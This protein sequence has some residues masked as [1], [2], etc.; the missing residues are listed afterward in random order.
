VR[1]RSGICLV[2][3]LA[4][5]AGAGIFGVLA[6]RQAAEISAYDHARACRAGAP[7]RADCLQHV[8]GA[9]TGVIEI[10]GKSQ[11]YA[12]DVRTA[13]TTLHVTF[14][15]D[16]PMLSDAVDG[17]PV[18]VTTWRGIPVAASADG[19]IEATA[20]VP[21]TAFA[22]DLGELALCGGG[23]ILLL[24]AAVGGRRGR[25]ATGQPFAR[26]VLAAWIM[27]LGLG[28]PLVLI[29]GGGALVT[30]PSAPGFALAVTGAA[31]FVVVGLGAWLAI[32]AGRRHRKRPADFG[33]RLPPLPKKRRPLMSRMARSLRARMRPAT[34][35]AVPG[36]GAAGWV[37]PLL[38]MAVLFGV[39]FT[40]RD[41]PPARAFRHAPACAGDARLAACVGDFTATVNGVRTPVQDSANYV[42]VS[43]VTGDDIINGWA[44]FDGDGQALGR[45]AEAEESERT[46][47]TIEVWRGSIVGAE[48]GDRW[49]WADG[50]PPGDTVPVVF[51]AIS[52]AVLLL[53]VRLG[54]HRRDGPRTGADR[55]RMVVEDSGQAAAAG[56]ATTLLAYGFWPGAIL[57]LAA[58]VWLGQSALRSPQPPL[59]AQAV[60]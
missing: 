21:E 9:V 44:Q 51:L 40:V 20:T 17:D 45:M 12:L 2:L 57:A 31:L 34:W 48:L 19:R 7:L 14:T 28:V 39:L 26:P 18:A 30:S 5:L 58:L 49:R 6:V 4:F 25:R 54:I 1:F 60:S 38:T 23:A 35:N 15:S 16:S 55:Q 32:Y 46:P 33:V 22:Q 36:S 52:F 41:G 10:G 27:V 47:L 59:P 29:A 53:V 50:D 37:T 3:G 43:Y 13:T 8:E 42:H 56:A 24:I 11:D